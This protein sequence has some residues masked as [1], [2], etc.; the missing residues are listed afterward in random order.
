MAKYNPI[1]LVEDDGLKSMEVGNW[2][3][4]KYKL[5]GKYCN[6]FT[7]GMRNKWNLVY[8]DPFCGPGYAKNKTSGQLMRNA[9]LAALNLPIPFDHY[10]FN[11]FDEASISAFEARA[12]RD[13]PK[14]SMLFFNADANDIMETM[15]SAIPKMDPDKG[16]LFFSFIDPFS[17]NL[18]FNTIRSLSKHNADILIL[19]A[20]QMDARRN[21]KNYCD[22][23]SDR[24]AKFIGREGWRDDYAKQDQSPTA[25]M[26]FVS[27]E[28]DRSAKAI[29]YMPAV[30]K[31]KITNTGG[32][33]IYY[34]AFYSKHDRG[35]D[36]FEKIRKT[37]NSQYEI[38]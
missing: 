24:I 16:N 17:L 7:S 8:L 19:H 3:Q 14:R 27:A 38:F 23:N 20:L 29:G 36:F 30:V 10:A 6:I 12:K 1:Q 37:N 34:L 33:G 4:M 32:H 26:K 35:L 31:E 25:F 5:V 28:F 15:I 2:A 22:E 13:S 11:D 21:H 9:G 18:N